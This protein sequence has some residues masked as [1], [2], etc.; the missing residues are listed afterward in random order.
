M[1]PC[2]NI[3][4]IFIFKYKMRI[5]LLTATLIMGAHHHSS[6]R[7][8]WC[9]NNIAEHVYD[10]CTIEA[11]SIQSGFLNDEIRNLCMGLPPPS[12]ETHCVPNPPSCTISCGLS[13]PVRGG[14]NIVCDTTPY[15]GR[16]FC[17]NLPIG[18]PCWDTSFCIAGS[19]CRGRIYPTRP[20]VCLLPV[21]PGSEC[22][23]DTDCVNNLPCAKRTILGEGGQHKVCCPGGSIVEIEGYILCG[24]GPY[25]QL[26]SF[27]I[28]CAGHSTGRCSNI[29]TG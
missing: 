1:F 26:C 15:D 19:R 27:D 4:N 25:G 6:C 22:F 12:I 10:V 29:C 24:N 28:Q 11:G 9:P 13:N 14:V 18:T 5:L 7:E 21:E 3:F 16:C 17:T 8:E 2:K 23:L 20:G